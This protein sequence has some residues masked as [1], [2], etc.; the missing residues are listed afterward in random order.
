[1]IF[2]SPIELEFI[3]LMGGKVVRFTKLR[4][5]RTKFPAAWIVSLGPM[6][7][8]QNVHREVRYGKY[9]VD[10]SNDLHRIIEIDGSA[11]HMDVVADMDREIYIKARQPGMRMMRIKTYELRNNKHSVQSRVI[12]FLDL[13]LPSKNGVHP[14]QMLANAGRVCKKLVR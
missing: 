8:A 14:R 3:E 10:F 12:D 7:K 11:Y 1:M 2:P 6:M 4:D 13:E 5:P 9:F